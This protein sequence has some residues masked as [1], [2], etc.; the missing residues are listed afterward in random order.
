MTSPLSAWDDDSIDH[1]KMEAWHPGDMP[2]P[3]VEESSFATLFPR[4][5]E[6]Y[7]QQV[8]PHV[9]RTLKD[10]VSGRGN[11]VSGRGSSVSGR[12]SSVSGRGSI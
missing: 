10:H 11:S 1:W 2:H 7:L 5:R 9:T 12:G 6:R 8:W 4:Y 3:I